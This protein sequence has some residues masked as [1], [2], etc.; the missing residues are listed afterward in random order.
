MN[1][2]IFVSDNRINAQLRMAIY[3][4]NYLNEEQRQDWNP[5]R[6]WFQ[7]GSGRYKNLKSSI[8]KNYTF[9]FLFQSN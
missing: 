6:N 7:D 9:I 1:L 8:E 2:M 4:N 5:N 3:N